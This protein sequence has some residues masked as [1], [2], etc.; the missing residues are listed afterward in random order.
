MTE[1]M[2]WTTNVSKAVCTTKRLLPLRVAVQVVCAAEIF[3]L[4]KVRVIPAGRLEN[5][6]MVAPLTLDGP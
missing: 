4:P 2:I 3:G 1:S 5:K 6:L